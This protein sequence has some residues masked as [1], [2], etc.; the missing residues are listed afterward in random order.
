MSFYEWLVFFHIFTTVVWIGGATMTLILATKAS[1]ADDGPRLA[2]VMADAEWVGLRVFTPATLV[3]LGSGLWMV[4]RSTAWSFNQFW[5]WLSLVVFGASFL[6]GILYYGPESG[7][8]GKLIKAHG[9]DA[10]EV[11]TRFRRLVWIF[12]LEWVVVVA[13]IWLMVAKPGL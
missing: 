12:R 9:P 2:A 3:L 8:I 7:R 1:R 6:A 13:V 5:I 10:D 11:K 4:F